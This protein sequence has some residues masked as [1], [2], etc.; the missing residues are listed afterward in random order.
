MEMV[1]WHMAH[2]GLWNNWAL[3]SGAGDTYRRFLASSIERAQVQQNFSMGA[4]WS[5]MTDPS[6]RSP[7]GE[8]NELL[9]WQQPHP[10]I[11]AEYEYRA[12]RSRQTLEKWKDVL[13]ETANWMAQWVLDNQLDGIDVD[14][15]VRM[16]SPSV[17]GG[18]PAYRLC[19]TGLGGDERP[20]RECGGVAR[21]LHRDAAQEAAKRTLSPD[22]RT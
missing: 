5:K 21:L 10:L 7:P 3:V 22:P 1:F 20:R 6:G 15:E 19:M 8:I 4:R 9:I 18:N 16:R 14:Y 13:N 12:T 17:K 11:F 2:W